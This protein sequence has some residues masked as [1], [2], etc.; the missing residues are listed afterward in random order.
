[1]PIEGHDKL[2]IFCGKPCNDVAGNPSEWPL[3]LPHYKYDDRDNFAHIGCT[4]ERLRAF[5]KV[6]KYEKALK[7][8]S[9]FRKLPSVDM[10]D[11]PEQQAR[12]WAN[13]AKRCWYEAERTLRKVDKSLEIENREREIAQIKYMRELCKDDPLLEP[14][15]TSR[16][17]SLEKELEILKKSIVN[18]QTDSNS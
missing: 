3:E 17:K 14:Q 8:I 16:L 7:Q 9:D 11:L 4:Y 15:W 13:A 1:M 2:C 18:N 10:A 6:D 5:S 12:D